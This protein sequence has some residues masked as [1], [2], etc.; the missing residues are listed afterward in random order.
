VLTKETIDYDLLMIGKN[1]SEN[2]PC[3][4]ASAFQ[5]NFRTIIIGV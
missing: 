1:L 3:D 2:E 5:A 4:D